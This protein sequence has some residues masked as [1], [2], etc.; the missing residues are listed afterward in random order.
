MKRLFAFG[1]SF[2]HYVW[3]TW[4]DAVGSSHFDQYYNYGRAGAGNRY[5]AEKILEVQ[6]HTTFTSDDVVVI[7]W[8]MFDHEDKYLPN[9]DQSVNI[10]EDSWFLEGWVQTFNNNFKEYIHGQDMLHR[11]RAYKKYVRLLMD[12][13]PC[14]FVELESI[15]EYESIEYF[16]SEMYDR[17]EKYKDFL[18][19]TEL[20]VLPI[21]QENPLPSWYQVSNKYRYPTN[22]GNFDFRLDTHPLPCDHL[23]II[24]QLLP[25]YKVSPEYVD[26]YNDITDQIHDYANT[27]VLEEDNG[28]GFSKLF[29]EFSR[30][31]STFH[32][33]VSTHPYDQYK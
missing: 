8:T 24:E 2:T 1:S 21:E 6:E 33:G 20:K 4:V 25:D 17:Y 11:D 29:K 28:W 16:N 13:L 27:K 23:D 12:T 26:L 7:L 32:K 19:L 9:R 22:I 5:I 3:P 31:Y 30:L 18:S 14:K 10:Y 15:K